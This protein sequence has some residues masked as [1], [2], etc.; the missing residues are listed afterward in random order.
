D[1]AGEK[2]AAM[3]RRAG[4]LVGERSEEIRM[5]EHAGA[6]AGGRGDAC[7]FTQRPSARGRGQAVEFREA[8]VGEEIVGAQQ[9]AEVGALAPYDLVDKHAERGAQIVDDVG[10]EIGKQFIVLAEVLEVAE[11]EPVLE[12]LADL[13]P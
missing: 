3:D 2:H 5:R 12:K 4:R 8:I 10:G 1:A 11:L 7:E 9:L 6:L 13:G